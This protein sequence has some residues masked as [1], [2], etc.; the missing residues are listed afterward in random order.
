LRIWNNLANQLVNVLSIIHFPMLIK[1]LSKLIKDKGTPF[2]G[3]RNWLMWFLLNVIMSFIVRN[4]IPEFSDLY[5]VLYKDEEVLASP[6]PNTFMS[7]ICMAPLSI[8]IHLNQQKNQDT[9]QATTQQN[10]S[11]PRS[12]KSYVIPEILQ[13]HLTL[14]QVN[15]FSWRQTERSETWIAALLMLAVYNNWK[16]ENYKLNNLLSLS[17]Y[18]YSNG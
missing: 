6:L 13:S 11:A 17:K 3:S 18:Y 15:K 4:R 14:L 1:S 7:V 8:W 12:A 16:T 10:T 2:P 5:E 9:N